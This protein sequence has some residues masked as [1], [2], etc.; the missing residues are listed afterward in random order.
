FGD[1]IMI[2]SPEVIGKNFA[3]QDYREFFQKLYEKDEV[4]ERL[5]TIFQHDIFLDSILTNRPKFFLKDWISEHTKE[6]PRVRMVNPIIIDEE[7]NIDQ[8]DEES[9]NKLDYATHKTIKAETVI[10]SPLWDTATWR[11]FGFFVLDILPLGIF[12]GFKNEEAAKEIF[13]EWI[14]I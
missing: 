12:L 13:E 5:S 1:L 7:A 11:G 14:N 6:Y 2:L 3:I 10:N 9:E 8:D 4:N